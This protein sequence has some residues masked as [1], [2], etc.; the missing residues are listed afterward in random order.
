MSVA[1]IERQLSTSEDG[2][3]SVD[4]EIYFTSLCESMAT[5][6]I[7]DR[8][9]IALVVT[10]GGSVPSRVSVSLGL[11]VT[12]LVTNALKYAF[13]NGREGQ[14][15]IGYQAHGPNWSLTVNDDGV[16]MPSDPSA[17]RTGLER[18]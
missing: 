16:A 15:E 6:M 11:I 17:I 12:E 7:G 5:A 13:P 2:D 10:G 4:L 1:T 14:I 9:R 18:T 8:Q 3:Q